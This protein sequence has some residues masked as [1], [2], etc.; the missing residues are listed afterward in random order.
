MT[1]GELKNRVLQLIFSYS[2]AGDEIELTYN[3]QEDYVKMIP[4]LLNK[5]QSEIYQIKTIEDSIL[6]KDLDQE[7][8]GNGTVLIHLPD[9]CL[10]VTPGRVVPRGR[11]HGPMFFRDTRYRLISG[12]KMIC[13]ADMPENTIL[14]YRRRAVPV[15]ENV[16]DTYVL[17]NPDEINDLIPFYIAAFLVMY[18]DAFRYSALYNE[19]ETGLQRLY[20]N[21]T[22]VEEQPIMDAY[23]GF[24]LGIWWY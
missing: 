12:N 1:Y 5:C 4:G 13:P 10:K 22:Y 17:K 6:L 7:D 14:E 19:F 3:N 2:I 20:P 23:N 15:P 18:D 24:D 9:D 21:P 8:M 16:K 11:Q